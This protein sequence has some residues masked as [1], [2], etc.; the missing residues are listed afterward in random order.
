MKNLKAIIQRDLKDCGVCCMQW[1]IKYYDGYI[2]LEKLR[3]DTFTDINGTSAYHIVNAFKKWGFDS[4]GVLEHD[5]NSSK[6]NFPLIAHLVLDNGLEHF[7]VVK[8]VVKNTVYIMDPGIGHTKT[9]ITKFTKLF[10]GHIIEALPREKI[11]KMDHELSINE[12]FLNIVNKEKLLIAK[13]IVTSIL[14]TI[15]LIVCSYYLKVGSILIEQDAGILKYTVI[16][17]G[18]LTGLKVFVLYVREY[19]ENHL[20]NLVDVYIYPEFLRHLFYLP[21]KVV[22]SRTTGEII[23]RISELSNIKSLFSDI[24][25][26]YFLD[27]IM[28]IISIV[29]LFIINKDLLF[30]LLACLLLYIVCGIIISKITYK[31]VLKNICYQTEFNSMIVEKIDMFESIK[32]LNVCKIILSK[33]ESSLSQYLLNNYEFSSFFNIANLVKDFILEICFFLINSYGFWL[34]LDGSITMVN[35]FTFNIILSYCVDPVKNIVNLLPKYNYIKASFSKITEF[36]NIEEEKI[37]DEESIMKGDIIFKDVSYSYNDYLYVLDKINFKIKEGSHVL[38]NGPSGCGKSTICKIIYGINEEFSGDVYV[39]NNNFKDINLSTIR[40]SIL[41]ISQNEELFTGSIREN[42]LIDREISEEKFFDICKI[43]EIDEII[44]KK[45]MRFDALVEPSSKNI[46][47][48]EKQRL[49]LARG[50]LKDAS[51]LILDEAL[52]EVDYKLESKI[53]KKIK[54]YFKDKTII[55]ISH[56]NQTKNFNNIIEL[57]VDN[58]KL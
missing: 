44:S 35:L 33:I 42:I 54:E 23:T 1:I 37:S 47:G 25:V 16:S 41:Y 39:G 17:F 11:I 28:V 46:S 8:Y 24:F 51:I 2:S 58:E 4:S 48:G 49:I 38:L 10:T 55:Y 26:S 40:S 3:E 21:L 14:W 36:I 52:S 22:K 12:L 18:L 20:S 9:N 57:G 53:I 31:K 19:Y 27:S 30:I 50:L 15:L 6:L 32:N 43:C 45:E 29:I 13:I 5:I 7:V 56:K 34:V